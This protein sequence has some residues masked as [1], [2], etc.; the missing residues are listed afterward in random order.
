VG[1][2]FTSCPP[3]KK[4]PCFSML[5]LRAAALRRQGERPAY[6]TLPMISAS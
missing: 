5:K 1:V 2:G 6:H 3:M 4:L